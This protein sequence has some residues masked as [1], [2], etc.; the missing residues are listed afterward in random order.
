MHVG[1]CNKHSQ[2][3]QP[4]FRG[5]IPATVLVSQ[6]SS[7]NH[8]MDMRLTDSHQ[9]YQHQN[10]PLDLIT[11]HDCIEFTQQPHKLVKK[12]KS[13][14]RNTFYQH[15]FIKGL[16]AYVMTNEFNSFLFS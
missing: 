4:Y 2:T 1:L 7:L 12:F 9:I 3:R 5:Q 14:H 6:Q 11:M 8:P 13:D 16:A 15:T 10:E